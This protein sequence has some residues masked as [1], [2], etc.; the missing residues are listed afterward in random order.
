MDNQKIIRVQNNISFRTCVKAN[1]LLL[2]IILDNTE[3]TDKIPKESQ[4]LFI[5]PDG[6]VFQGYLFD[7]KAVL[8]NRGCALYRR[9]KRNNAHSTTRSRITCP[10]SFA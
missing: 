1:D 6:V 2:Q 3:V 8:W 4:G 5:T 10:L 9:Q 7:E